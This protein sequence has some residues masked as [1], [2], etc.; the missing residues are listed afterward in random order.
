MDHLEQFAS[1]D[2]ATKIVEVDSISGYEYDWSL[3]GW[4]R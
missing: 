4:K 1:T 3:N 2:L